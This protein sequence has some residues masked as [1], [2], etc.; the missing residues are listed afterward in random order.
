MGG[1]PVYYSRFPQSV[2]YSSVKVHGFRMESLAIKFKEVSLSVINN[3][4]S[5]SLEVQ[6]SAYFTCTHCLVRAEL[7]DISTLYNV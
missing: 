5:N 6:R 1:W 7:I 2:A 4:K 3:E